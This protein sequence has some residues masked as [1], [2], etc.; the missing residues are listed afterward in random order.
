[1]TWPGLIWKNLMR[2]PGRRR[3]PPPVSQSASGSSS[4]CCRSPPACHNTANDLIHVGRADFGLFQKDVT[5]LTKS[6]LPD[7][8][9]NQI[10]RKPGVLKT[11]NVYLWVG[12]V[13]GKSS[14]LVFGLDPKEFDYRRLVIVQG[15][16]SG[17]LLGDHAAK[18]L[19]LGPGD[20]CTSRAEPSASEAS[21]TPGTASRT[22]GPCS[23]S[24]PCR[25]SP[26]T[27]TK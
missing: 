6:L 4:R 24:R 10:G 11:A 19:D 15:T 8:L 13:E 18:S 14:F 23:R 25:G 7:T 2:R 3:S 16:P 27:R 5:D 12:K 9:E 1:V 17:A 21:T 20:T 26:A 22:A